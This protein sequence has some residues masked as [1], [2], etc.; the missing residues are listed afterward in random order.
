MIKNLFLNYAPFT[1]Y[2]LFLNLPHSHPQTPA[3]IIINIGETLNRAI[4]R[5]H[6][7]GI[8]ML[9]HESF[10]VFA[11]V[12]HGAAIRA[13]TAGRTPRKNLPT[14]TLSLNVW[15]NM[16]MIKMAMMDGRAMP[17]APTMPP[18]TPRNL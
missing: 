13:T 15:K 16:A 10:A 12:K 8:Q 1:D 11:M 18:H 9:R 7:T 5:Q 6:T 17:M 4:K 3:V 2:S 14:Y